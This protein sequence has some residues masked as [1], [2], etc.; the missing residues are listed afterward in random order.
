L[1]GNE[2][3]GGLDVENAVVDAVSHSPSV[4]VWLRRRV[5]GGMV[6]EDVTPLTIFR[7]R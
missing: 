6:H 5:S 4:A 1:I 7:T 2:A 3:L